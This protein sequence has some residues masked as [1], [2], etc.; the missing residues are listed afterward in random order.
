MQAQGLK[1]V[2]LPYSPI[3]INSL[4]FFV[5]KE[6][7]L[8]EKYGLDVD[9][10]FIG[11]SSVVFQSMLSGAADMAGSGG[12]AV[13]ANVLKGG[14]IIQ[15]AATV[16]RFTQSLLVK[17]EVKKVENL[18]GKKVGISR[19][20]TVTH[21]ALQTALEGYGIKDVTVLQMGGQP[22]AL[23]GLM[24]GSIDGAI[25][26]PPQSFQLRNQG[27]HELVTPNDLQKLTEFITTGIVAR[28]AVADKNR[29]T[30]LRMIKGTTEAIKYISQNEGFA[31]KVLSQY[32]HLSDPELLDQ[33]YRFATETFAKEPLVS[34]GAI[35]SMV[36]Q[37]V[38]SNMADSRA[39]SSLPLTAYYDNSFVDELKR[40]GFFE[41][42]WK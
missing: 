25:V 10:V 7:R 18:R 28:R 15:V 6:A 24:R 5:A 12:P 11:A 14:D 31:K 41:E 9:L 37:M 35:R 23:A 36:R 34:P 22:E 32:V 38:Q 40:S 1:K 39:A 30:V 2:L 13:I 33:S 26:Y 20:G 21:F 3:G 4:P 27:F 16:P 29:D 19:L 42:L 17:P 8:F